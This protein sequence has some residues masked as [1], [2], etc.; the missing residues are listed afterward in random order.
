M[1]SKNSNSNQIDEQ[2][3]NNFMLKAV[4]DVASSMSA[5]LTI[6]GERLGLYK[7]LTESGPLTSE[8]LAIKTSTHERYVREW[9]ANQAAGGYINYDPTSGKF[10]LPVEQSMVLADE[11]S[12]V[13][14]HGAYQTIK[15]LFKDEEKFVEMF[16]TGKGLRWGE[17]HHDLFDGTARFFKPNYVGNLIQS[18]IPSLDGIEQK[19]HEG[20]R[21]ADIGCG[22]G[23]ST[24]LMAKAFPNSHFFGFDNHTPSIETAKEGAKKEGVV[25]N[26]EFRSVSANESIGNDYDFI[27]FFDCLHDMGNPI[28]AMK[29][30][31]QSLKNDGTCMIVEPMANDNLKDNLNLVGRVFYAASTLV[32]VPN[33]LADSGPGLG[34]QAGEKRIREVAEKA[35]FTRFRRAIQTPFNIIYEVKP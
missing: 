19:L 17:H 5:M 25:E 13:Y 15:S 24:I 6:L 7:A 23:V 10:A 21:V 3:L 2:L 1:Q 8:E 35:G 28:G 9:L 4:G 20:A 11:N 12:P 26:L 29:F 33:S 22:Y 18:W 30:A 14:I 34:A 32:C 31:K 27:T 16:K